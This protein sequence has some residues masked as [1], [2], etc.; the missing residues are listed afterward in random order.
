[1]M[2]RAK[3]AGYVQRIKAWSFS[4]WEAYN[5]CPL[6][7]KYK[8]LDK[9]PEPPSPALEKGKKAHEV[10]ARFMAGFAADR[11]ELPGWKHFGELM[12]ELRALEPLVEQQWGY[13]DQWKPTDW[14]GNDTWFRAVLDAGVV[15]KD[16]TADV[17]DFKTGKPSPSH[18]EQAE[19]YALSVLARYPSV[20]DVAVRFWY[21]EHGKESVFEFERTV[22]PALKEKWTDKVQHMLEDT[23]FAPRPGNHCRWCS[24]AA[25]KEGPCKHG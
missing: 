22:L 1:M 12:V 18:A 11:H 17:V 15:Y 8:F 13:T 20:T 7:A 23:T 4:R 21:L 5:R 3:W 24:F 9:I 16:N 14:F 2:S 10:L 19:L 6:Q 25:S